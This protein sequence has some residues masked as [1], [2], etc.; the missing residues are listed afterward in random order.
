MIRFSTAMDLNI[1]ME[2]QETLGKVIM[3]PP[4]TERLLSK[5]PFRFLHDIL[6]EVIRNTRVLKGLYSDEEMNSSNI[7]VMIFFMFDESRQ[8]IIFLL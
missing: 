4:L 1:L 2:T 8:T 5:P 7:T 6:T 3:K